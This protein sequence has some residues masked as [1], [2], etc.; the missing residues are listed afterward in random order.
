MEN[1]ENVQT[2]IIIIFSDLPLGLF[3][4][5]TYHRQLSPTGIF[6]F[7]WQNYRKFDVF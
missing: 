5:V 3:L 7:R 1:L 4:S 6:P 2:F